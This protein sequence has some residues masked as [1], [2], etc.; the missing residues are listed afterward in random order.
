MADNDTGHFVDDASIMVTGVL[1]NHHGS[2]WS[3][4]V[5][6][7]SLPQVN[8]GIQWYIESGLASCPSYSPIYN[9]FEPVSVKMLNDS[10][11]ESAFIY[12]DDL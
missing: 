3:R 9:C 8:H 4:V 1:V 11:I 10:K 12:N 5:P 7:L 2:W 6:D